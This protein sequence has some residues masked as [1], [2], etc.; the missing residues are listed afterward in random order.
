MSQID[1][2]VLGLTLLAIISYGLYKS[3]SSKTLDGYFRSDRSMP[4]FL[5]LL[6]IMG[7]QASAITG[8]DKPTAMGCALCNTTSACRLR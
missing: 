2:W 4:W 5:I 8:P 3:R 7:T 6:S 1:F